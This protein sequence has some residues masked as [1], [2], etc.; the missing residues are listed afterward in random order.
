[1]SPPV[2]RRVTRLGR[3][4]AARRL[5]R[6][7]PDSRTYTSHPPISQS[8]TQY[9][10]YLLSVLI[11]CARSCRAIPGTASVEVFHFSGLVLLA[12]NDVLVE[13]LDV[14]LAETPGE[15]R[16][17]PPLQRAV[18]QYRAEALGADRAH[19][20]EVGWDRRRAVA[21]VAEHTTPVQRATARH[22]CWVGRRQPGEIRMR[23]P[24]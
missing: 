14:V 24:L 22:Q 4:R 23:R 2:L 15:T 13:R 20:L 5:P 3:R 9:T 19:V 18:E 17:P 6:E 10:E 11:L 12:A 7:S 21:S 1:M 8:L 16:H